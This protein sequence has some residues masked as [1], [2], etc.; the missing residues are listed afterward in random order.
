V[1]QQTVGE[2]EPVCTCSERTRTNRRAIL[3][4]TIDSKDNRP[5]G[6]VIHSFR[7]PHSNNRRSCFLIREAKRSKQLCNS[8]NEIKNKEIEDGGLV[9]SEK[10]VRTSSEKLKCSSKVCETELSGAEL[11]N[12]LRQQ[13]TTAG[14]CNNSTSSGSGELWEEEILLRHIKECRCTCNHMGYGNYLDWSEVSAETAFV[15][16]LHFVPGSLS[17]YFIHGCLFDTRT[18]NAI[19]KLNT[20]CCH[21]MNIAT[22]GKRLII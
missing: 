12:R 3:A 9:L 18:N 2:M 21:L 11:K 14:S 8:D 10:L 17:A 7:N 20:Y 16:R 1:F 22:G 4:T 19:V 15:R 13:V 5:N 6:S